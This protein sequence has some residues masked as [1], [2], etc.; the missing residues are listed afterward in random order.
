MKTKGETFTSS[1]DDSPSAVYLKRIRQKL[2]LLPF[3]PYY[4]HIDGL[5]MD[6]GLD[7]NRESPGQPWLFQELKQGSDPRTRVRWP[8]IM[9]VFFD[10]GA[11][12]QL[13]G[14]IFNPTKTR[15]NMEISPILNI[16]SPSDVQISLHIS[17]RSPTL[18]NKWC[19]HTALGKFFS[20]SL[21]YP[22]NVP[23]L[24]LHALPDALFSHVVGSA[25]DPIRSALFL[26]DKLTGVIKAHSIPKYIRFLGNASAHVRVSVNTCAWKSTSDLSPSLNNRLYWL[27]G[28]LRPCW[29]LWGPPP[30]PT[31]PNAFR[32]AASAKHNSSHCY[33]VFCYLLAPTVAMV[34]PLG[35]PHRSSRVYFYSNN[36]TET[37]QNTLMN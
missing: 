16:T 15:E 36:I 30:H 3:M 32:L 18:Q 24:R 31:P 20:F 6:F 10:G 23:Q 35:E 13:L 19:K 14:F 29:G 5:R 27:N 21:F 2:S 1:D 33:L 9:A 7:G 25:Q 37:K 17:R 28:T 4:R 11:S 34:S 12:H 26:Q 22:F 8:A